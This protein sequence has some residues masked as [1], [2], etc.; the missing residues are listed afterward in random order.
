MTNTKQQLLILLLMARTCINCLT[1]S[2]RQ[3]QFQRNLG[4]QEQTPTCI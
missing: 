1:K 4:E 2:G 3:A